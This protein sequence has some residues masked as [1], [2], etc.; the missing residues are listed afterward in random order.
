MKTQQTHTCVM[1]QNQLWEGDSQLYMCALEKKETHNETC[2]SA[3][4][5]LPPQP[6]QTETGQ[7]F[8]WCAFMSKR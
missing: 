6:E 2:H 1:R 8:Q 4:G 3:H 7:W 5:L